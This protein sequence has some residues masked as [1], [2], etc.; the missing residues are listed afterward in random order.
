MD[1]VTKILWKIL[2]NKIQQNIK[3]RIHYYQVG[4]IPEIQDWLNIFNM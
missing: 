1:M 2:A 3:N 4:F